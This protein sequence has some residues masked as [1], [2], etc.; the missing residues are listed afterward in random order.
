MILE[1]EENLKKIS[2][3]KLEKCVYKTETER[4]EKSHGYIRLRLIRNN[5]KKFLWPGI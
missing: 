4:P 1:T 2:V 3:L 5:F